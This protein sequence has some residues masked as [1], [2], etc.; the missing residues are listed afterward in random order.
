VLFVHQLTTFTMGTSGSAI[1]TITAS[2]QRYSTNQAS[3]TVADP[4]TITPSTTNPLSPGSQLLSV[5]ANQSVTWLVNPASAGS[6]SASTSSANVSVTFTVASPIPNSAM[7]AT[8]TATGSGGLTASLAVNLL[9][10]VTITPT[11]P[12]GLASGVI[13]QFSANIPVNWTVGTTNGGSVSPAATGAGQATTF[14]MG[15]ASGSVTL[16]AADQR[17]ST[18]SASVTIPLGTVAAAVSVSPNGSSQQG[19]SEQT[20]TFTFSDTG[21]ASTLT[22]VSALIGASTSSMADSCVVTY[23]VA[24]NTLALLTDAGLPPSSTITPGSGTAQNSQCILTGSGSTVAKSGAVLTLTL[25]LGATEWFGVTEGIYGAAQ[26]VT[27]SSPGWT[28]LGTWIIPGMPIIS[29][30]NAFNQQTAAPTMIPGTPLSMTFEAGDRGGSGEIQLVEIS[31]GVPNTGSGS[32]PASGC[33]VLFDADTGTYSLANNSGAWVSGG[34]TLSNSQCMLNV[35]SSSTLTLNVDPPALGVVLNIS[36][37]SSY[38]GIYPVYVLAEDQ[39]GQSSGWTLVGTVTVNQAGSLTISSITVN[40]SQSE[41]TLTAPQTAVLQVTLTGIAPSG[42]AAVQLISGHPE[43]FPVPSTLTVPAGSSSAQVT[44]T[45]IQPPSGPVGLYV[46]ASYG[47]VQDYPSP[48]IL[49]QAGTLTTVTSNPVGLNISVDGSP[50]ITPCAYNWIS[51]ISHTFLTTQTIAGSTGTQYYFQNWGAGLTALSQSISVTAG[52][53]YMATF[54]TQY[55]LTVNQSAGGTITVNTAPAEAGG[56]YSP[57]TSVSLTASANY[58]FSNFS[59]NVG[60]VTTS[61]SRSAS[62]NVV[63]SGPQTVTATFN[64][65]SGTTTPVIA[66]VTISPSP[67]ISGGTATLTVTLTQPV[68]NATA[69]TLTSSAS[70]TLP[71]PLTVT[72]PANLPSYTSPPFTVGPVTTATQVTVT[73]TYG[74]GSATDSLL[75]T[76]SVVS[77]ASSTSGAPSREYIRLG[78]RVIAIENPPATTGAPVMSPAPGGYASAPLV[79]LTAAAGATIYYTTNGTTPSQSNGTLYNGTAI[80]LSGTETIMAVAVVSGVSG[81]AATGTYTI[82]TAGMG[83]DFLRRETPWLPRRAV[84]SVAAAEERPIDLSDSYRSRA[85]IFRRKT[86]VE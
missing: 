60:G 46:L 72:V 32:G 2:D 47:S 82:A 59:A 49:V 76:F 58:Q 7:T 57:G 53:I 28:S 50:C 43:V 48:E 63:M 17:Y 86:N 42:G 27:G 74:S 77:A 84:I 34:G 78:G 18:N 75:G 52:S 67:V 20:L 38:Q 33:A 25:A 41:V 65:A 31:F 4:P 21:G 10:A 22:T 64:G 9:P 5:S 66:S 39:A 26:D 37:M 14:T 29:S 61:G 45:T 44:I 54:Q 55:L 36:F 73:A 69:V 13:A 23:N 83:P 3:T 56:W 6:F 81:A 24:Q 70:G 71:V 68:S 19:Y 79:T 40:N 85:V 8:I 51:G 12:S 80:Q 1:V 16:T 62:G 15:T 35:G 30:M 11:K